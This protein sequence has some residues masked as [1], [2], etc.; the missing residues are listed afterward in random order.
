[1][2]SFHQRICSVWK[3]HEGYDVD[4]GLDPDLD[5]DSDLALDS[6]YHVYTCVYC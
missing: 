2:L 6:D 4:G 1:M 3:L 5:L